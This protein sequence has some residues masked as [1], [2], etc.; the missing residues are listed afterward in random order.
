MPNPAVNRTL[1]TKPRKAGYLERWASP[2][3][4][5]TLNYHSHGSILLSKG[6]RCTLRDPVE[7]GKSRN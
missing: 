4:H 5:V 6:G 2:L 1:R 3:L 7:L